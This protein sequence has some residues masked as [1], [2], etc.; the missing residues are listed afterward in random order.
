[1]NYYDAEGNDDYALIT[2]FN[3]AEDLIHLDGAAEDYSLG[4]SSPDL[5]EGISIFQQ[6]E[7]IAIVQ[8]AAIDLDAD[9]FQYPVI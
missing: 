9:Y 8:G 3:M 5:P 4:A 6:E 1:N 2:D 7:L